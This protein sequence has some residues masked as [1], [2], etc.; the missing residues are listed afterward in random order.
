MH[1]I[2]ILAIYFTKIPA[3]SGQEQDIEFDYLRQAKQNRYIEQM[4]QFN[5][6]TVDQA[7]IRITSSEAQEAIKAA[8]TGYDARTY[9]FGDTVPSWSLPQDPLGSRCL[10]AFERYKGQNCVAGNADR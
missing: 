3:A 8:R 5:P 4:L 2:C 7:L 6:T 1:L 10:R 9:R